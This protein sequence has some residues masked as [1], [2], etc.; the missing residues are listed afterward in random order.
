[1]VITF[2][3]SNGESVR[4]AKSR[5]GKIAF[6]D[7]KD[8]ILIPENL[9]WPHPDI[10]K[11]LYKSNRINS[12]YPKDIP[13]LTKKLGFY[14]DLQSLRS[15]DAITWSAFGTL[16]AFPKSAQTDFLNSVLEKI[17]VNHVNSD[18]LLQCW[19]RIA[20]PEKLVSGG[21]EL[22]FQFIGDTTIV[23][24]ESKWRSNISRNQGKDRNKDQIQLRKEFLSNYGASIFRTQKDRFVIL[25]GREEETNEKDVHY[26]SWKTVCT[27]LNHPMGADLERY[28]RW[29][30][31]YG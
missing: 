2:K 7:Y 19:A 1:M 27:E 21:P 28:Y 4:V 16:S 14:C 11:K 20:H 15:E 26:L 13:E 17:G 29:K 6:L 24:I 8:N 9:V 22:D 5:G 18:C 12:F 3:N 10:V 23:Y 30:M 25:V 31:R